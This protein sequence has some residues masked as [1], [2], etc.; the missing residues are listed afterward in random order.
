MNFLWKRKFSKETRKKI[1]MKVNSISILINNS[2]TPSEL[3]R[4]GVDK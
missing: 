4:I 1:E 2:L 3:K